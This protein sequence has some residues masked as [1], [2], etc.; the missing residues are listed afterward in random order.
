MSTFTGALALIK[1]NGETVGKIQNIRVNENITRVDVRELGNIIPVESPVTQ[2]AGTFSCSIIAVDF[3]K[4][5]LKNAIRRD[6]QS[7]EEFSDNLLL[8]PNGIQVDIFKKVMD[9]ID[10]NTGLIKSK[11][12][13]FAIVGKVLI[14]SDAFNIN[15][16]QVVLRDQTFRFLSPVIYPK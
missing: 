16:G 1:V 3:S 12:T 15:E 10:P 9:A 7:E 14:D 5:G 11:L 4:G 6:V 8:N 2:W 13:P